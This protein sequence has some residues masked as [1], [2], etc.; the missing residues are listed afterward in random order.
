MK[1]SYSF[2]AR[3]LWTQRSQFTHEQLPVSDREIIMNQHKNRIQNHPSSAVSKHNSRKILQNNPL[4][5][6]DL[7]CPYRDKSC[8]YLV[9]SIDGD[10]CFIK[11][12]VGNQ[13]RAYSYKIKTSEYYRVSNENAGSV[14]YICF[15]NSDSDDDV[16]IPTPPSPVDI[17][18]TQPAEYSAS[19]HPSP[20]KSPQAHT[21]YDHKNTTVIPILLGSQENPETVQELPRPPEPLVNSHDQLNVTVPTRQKPQRI[22]HPPKYLEDYVLDW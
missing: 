16:E 7:V 4:T 1:D 18:A 8:R 10:W 15:E 5:V 11:K 13:L 14:P 22:S 2:S 3:E 6:G 21:A 9:V 19:N 12:F 17:P 20:A